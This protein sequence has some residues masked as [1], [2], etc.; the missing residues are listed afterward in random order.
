MRGRREF[1]FSCTR[2]LE[3]H[4]TA[5]QSDEHYSKVG[6]D[7]GPVAWEKKYLNSE[8]KGVQTTVYNCQRGTQS[9]GFFV[10]SCLPFPLL[11]ARSGVRKEGFEGSS[12]AEGAVYSYNVNRIPH[13]RN[14]FFRHIM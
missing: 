7:T 2:A 10:W 12:C 5:R 8:G 13:D 3:T 4:T 11:T 14:R 1:A 6:L 9:V